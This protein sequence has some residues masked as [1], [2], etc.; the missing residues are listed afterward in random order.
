MDFY[1]VAAFRE[2]RWVGSITYRF[3]M[4]R[5]SELGSVRF[6]DG[7]GDTYRASFDLSRYR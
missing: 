3:P 4:P 7:Y 1:D 6:A 5:C 2:Q